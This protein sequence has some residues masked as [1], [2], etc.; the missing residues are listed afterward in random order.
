MAG[1]KAKSGETHPVTV[2]N[3]AV[4]AYNTAIIRF[5]ESVEARMDRV[6][7]LRM[8]MEQVDQEVYDAVFEEIMG[9]EFLE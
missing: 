1:K 9:R 2:Y 4:T 7:Q 5:N 6:P 3:E 8:L